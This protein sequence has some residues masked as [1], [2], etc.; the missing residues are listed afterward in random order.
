MSLLLRNKSQLLVLIL[1]LA[2][3]LP[4]YIICF[5]AL[6]FADDFSYAWAA[7]EKLP[8]IQKFLKQYL[9]W[10]GRYTADTF[11]L[12]HPLATGKIFYYQLSLFFSL[13]ITPAVIFLFIRQMVMDKTIS[14]FSTLFVTLFYLNYLPNLTEGVYWYVG[15]VNYHLGNLLLLLQITLL[16]HLGGKEKRNLLLEFFSYVLLIISVGFNEIS[17]FLI[18]VFYLFASALAI[19]FNTPTKRVVL[20]HLAVAIFA[21]AFV[22]LSPGNLVRAN[23]FPERYQLLHS[24]FYS[25]LQTIRFIGTWSLNYPFISLSLLIAANANKISNNHAHKID[26]RLLLTVLLFSVFTAS[27]IPYFATGILGQHRTINYVLFFFILLWLL[28][29]LSASNKFNLYEK[30]PFFRKKFVMNVTLISSVLVLFATKEIHIVRDLASD[31]FHIYKKEFMERQEKII[32]NTAA[33]IPALRFIP[34]TFTIVDTKNDSAF[35][36]DRCVRKFYEETKIRL[37]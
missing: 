27:F 25:S 11:H 10:N 1:L 22:F 16:L 37:E 28:F 5:Y 29:L 35:V 9:G 14:I 36:A 12:F 23:E 13:L 32:Q 26:Y 4:Y 21:A 20:Y 24:L 34:S 33:N 7:S 17:A 3:L 15:V 30:L 18:P 6:P 8:F 31:N 19:K 2:A